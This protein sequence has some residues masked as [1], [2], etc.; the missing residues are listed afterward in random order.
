MQ[1]RT[2]AYSESSLAF[3]EAEKDLIEYS[4]TTMYSFMNQT[5]NE[6]V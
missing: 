1:D 5:I 6:L 4:N 2:S 3:L